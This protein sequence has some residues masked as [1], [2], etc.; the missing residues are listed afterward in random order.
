MVPLPAD[1]KYYVVSI[2]ILCSSIKH[3]YAYLEIIYNL[4]GGK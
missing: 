4:G 2:H 1:S 3:Y